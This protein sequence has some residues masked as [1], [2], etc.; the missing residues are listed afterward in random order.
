M[1]KFRVTAEW[2]TH[3][4]TLMQ[5][6]GPWETSLRQN[7]ADII[8]VVS[9]YEP[10][11][12]I[13]ETL[14]ELD[15]ARAYLNKAGVSAENVTWHIAGT[16]NAW[17]R[18]NGPI[19]VTD[20]KTTV[21]Q[22]HGFDAWGGNFGR[23]VTFAKDDRIPE[24]VARQLGAKRV[25]LGD[26]VVEKGNLEFNGKGT[27]ML[28]WDCQANRNPGMSKAAHEAYLKQTLGVQKIVW[29]YGADPQD[30]TT[31][32][33]AWMRSPISKSALI[34]SSLIPPTVSTASPRFATPW[35]M[36]RRAHSWIWAAVAASS[37][38]ALI[39]MR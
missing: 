2:E 26:Y 3:A 23:D 37:F 36:T 30:G 38:P 4:A 13:V 25:D 9:K 11:H 39:S 8:K 31:G 21:V 32:H 33:L 18:D 6:P 22:D 24:F 12:L 14:R 1:I 7:F 29:A 19:Y 16:D 34:G 27:L 17:M 20:G 28:N 35:S 10:M 15:A 5:W